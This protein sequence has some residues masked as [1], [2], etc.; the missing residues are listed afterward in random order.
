MTIR[1]SRKYILAGNHSLLDALYD[2]IDALKAKVELLQ[3]QHL[4]D[5]RRLDKL[6]QDFRA[7]DLSLV[8]RAF[9]AGINSDTQGVVDL[10]ATVKSLRQQHLDKLNQAALA[11]REAL[12]AAVH[13]MRAPLDEWKGDLERK[14]LDM[15]NA[16]WRSLKEPRTTSWLG[17]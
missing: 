8:R 11:Q 9:I 14:A 10:Q 16:C 17:D 7:H 3:K 1:D 5:V 2:Q 4:E 6:N 13:A 12:I 15:A